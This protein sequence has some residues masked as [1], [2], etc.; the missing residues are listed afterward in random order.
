MHSSGVI[1]SSQP[2]QLSLRHHSAFSRHQI[3]HTSRFA[4]RTTLV[5]ASISWQAWE[6]H[7]PYHPHQPH[8]H[9]H[10]P[11]THPQAYS[12]HVAI[13]SCKNVQPDP[14]MTSKRWMQKKGIEK[15]PCFFASIFLPVS[16][17]YS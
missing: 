15:S 7:P 4:K 16:S 17:S 2:P 10:P 14:N 13:N 3:T 6:A 8:L 1:W 5:G 11:S 12:D 9:P